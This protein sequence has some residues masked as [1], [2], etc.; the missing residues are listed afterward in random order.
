MT[1][2]GRFASGPHPDL[3][4]LSASIETDICL[5]PYDIA[6]TGAHARVLSAA[7]L[8]TDRELELV[9]GALAV[10]EARW[11]AGAMTVEGDEDVHSLVERL[12]T[13]E[14]GDVGARIHAGRSR[15]DLV[16]TDLRLWCRSEAEAVVGL[17]VALLEALRRVAAP[18]V[19]T[20]MPGYT[21]LQ[22]AQ[23]VS[24]AFHLLAHGFAMVRDGW[25][26]VAAGNAADVS[27]LGA[28]AL[29][30]NTLG[31][32]PAL[33]AD[34]LGFGASF[35]NAMDAVAERDFACDFLYAAALCGVHLSRLAEEIV[36]WTST[37]FGF[38]RLPDEWSTG[39]SMMPQK[40]NPDLAE[41]IRGR[42]AGGIGDLAALL[43]LLKGL[44]LAYNRDLQ[45]DK[46]ALFSGAGRVRA[47]LEAMTALVGALSFDA[48]RLTGAATGTTMWATDLAER[49][50]AR[51]VP[52]RR[53]HEATGGLVADLERLG[54]GLADAPVD[55]LKS[56]HGLLEP[57]DRDLADPREGL[58]A[59]SSAGGA[60]PER[61][62]E[63]LGRLEEA[64]AALRAVRRGA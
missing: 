19:H 13:Q 12:L 6:A 29:A 44:P 49:L 20:I 61:V 16:A 48:D 27:P 60:S 1:W 17:I 21:H 9:E 45:E 33:G 2:G 47:G 52:F 63:Q 31:L 32:D 3:V 22:R 40:R 64:G 36:L 5:L 25:R 4:R 26:F 54:I 18:H 35:D 46:G 53:A 30:G 24:L 42:A 37:E 43:T 8:L 14:L 55:L 58:A 50:V 56:H 51:G 39:S 38:A 11:R 10:I 41:L 23:P 28:G 57:H 7:K 59:R 62:G 15:N 34:A